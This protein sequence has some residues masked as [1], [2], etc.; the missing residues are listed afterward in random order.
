MPLSPWTNRGTER[1]AALTDL[2]NDITYQFQVRAVNTAGP[3]AAVA[4]FATPVELPG[5]P[6]DLQGA[7]S[8]AEIVWSWNASNSGGLVTGYEY[9]GGTSSTLTGPWTTTSITNIAHSVSISSSPLQNGVRYYFQVRGIN[10]AGFGPAASSSAIPQQ[11]LEA[12]GAPRSLQLAAGDEQ[13]AVSWAAPNT[14]GPVV[15]YEYRFGTG[16]SLSGNWVSNG[17]SQDF[18]LSEASNGTRYYFQIRAVNATGAGPTLSGS[19]VP[20]SATTPPGKPVAARGAAGSGSITWS[21]SAGLGGAPDYY[22]YRIGTGFNLTGNWSTTENTS[23]NISGVSG[24]RYYFQVRAVNAGGTSAYASTNNVPAAGVSVPGTPSNVR[25]TAYSGSVS[26]SWSAASGTVASYEYRTSSSSSFSG[27]WTSNG[28]S[29]SVST[30]GTN[31]VTIYFQVRARNSSGPGSAASANKAPVASVV[32]LPRPGTP[33]SISG[34][35]STSSISWSWGAASGTVSSYE[36][37]LNSGNWI[38]NGSSRSITTSGNAGSSYS[39]RVR[40]RNSSGV[41]STRT[42]SSVTISSVPITP[43]AAPGRPGGLSG[44]ANNGYVSWSWDASSGTVSSYEYRTSSSSSFSGG[45]TGNGSSRSASTSG[46]NGVTIYFQVRARNSS[47]S[48]NAASANKAPVAP[49]I[50]PPILSVPGLPGTISSSRTNTSIGWGWG[51]ASGTV[52]SY[53]YRIF[54][55]SSSG[56]WID[57]GSSLGFGHTGIEGTTYSIQVRARNASG[58]GP[59]RSSSSVTVPSA[60][61]VPGTPGSISVI[62][63]HGSNASILWSWGAASGTVAS[64]EYKIN[65]GGWTS[66]GTSRSLAQSLSPQAFYQLSVRARNSSGVGP[67]RTSS[68]DYLYEIDPDG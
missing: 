20:V 62:L 41:G 18:L 39:L 50:V 29:R 9:R 63:G 33:G 2:E 21:W 43:L 6:G 11:A 32:S 22:E 61:A 65:N 10:L 46:T 48:G 8:D 12:P 16:S 34:I 37:S 49:V 28:S 45:W 53:E 55:G 26:W 59:V 7:E 66:N 17:L 58:V 47:G 64:Y 4:G 54:T 19:S 3:G 38:S 67:V 27:G 35:A 52:A 23:I 57:N 25:G 1:T 31:G 44:T 15:R 13:I 36:Y 5:M 14:G 68:N 60:L 40:A 51:A 24:T 42:S 56:D 30:S